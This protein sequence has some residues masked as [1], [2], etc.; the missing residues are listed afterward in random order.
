MRSQATRRKDV[1]KV[2]TSKCNPENRKIL[3][4]AKF[5]YTSND[6]IYAKRIVPRFNGFYSGYFQNTPNI[7]T[8][9]GNAFLNM[10]E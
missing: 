10:V 1:A 8:F 9:F 6:V 7:R 4:P 3:A 2:S 5:R